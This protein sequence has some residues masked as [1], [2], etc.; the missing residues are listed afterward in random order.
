MKTAA[1]GM[2]KSTKPRLTALRRSAT[3]S[4]SVTR[5]RI[6]DIS[7]KERRKMSERNRKHAPVKKLTRII[8]SAKNPLYPMSCRR[9]MVAGMERSGSM[10]KIGMSR[11]SEPAIRKGQKK[12]AVPRKNTFVTR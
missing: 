10:P 2:I 11:I 8:G 4:F 9:R 5:A 6:L 12:S 7:V 1:H 3:P